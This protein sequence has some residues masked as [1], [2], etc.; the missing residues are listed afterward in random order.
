MIFILIKSWLF[1]VWLFCFIS[2]THLVLKMS[3]MKRLK[4]IWYFW[5]GWGRGPIHSSCFDTGGLHSDFTRELI[6]ASLTS[7]GF[8]ERALYKMVVFQ[9]CLSDS[10]QL[11][12]NVLFQ[13]RMDVNRHK[14]KMHCLWYRSLLVDWGSFCPKHFDLLQKLWFLYFIY[15]IHHSFQVK[16]LKVAY[17]IKSNMVKYN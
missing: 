17:S 7:E 2:S 3:K 14:S 1:L 10:V 11:V 16:A 13:W 8:D 5:I 12:V 4:Q 15:S 6:Q 9:L